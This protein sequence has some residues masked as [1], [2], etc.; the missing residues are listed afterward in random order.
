MACDICRKTGIPLEELKDE[1]QTDKIKSICS[2]CMRDINSHLFQIK[3][4]Q[5]KLT[6]S[7]LKRFM[8]LLRGSA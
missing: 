3:R 5:T 8:N 2:E 4:I 1:Y 6:H 7:L